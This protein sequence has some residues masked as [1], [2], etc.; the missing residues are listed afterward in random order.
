MGEG[1]EPE[2]VSD[3]RA[4]ALA[5]AI[6]GEVEAADEWLERAIDAA[7]ADPVT[8]DVVIVLREH[9]GRATEHEIAIGELVRGTPFPP[10][11]GADSVQ[12]TTR[13]IA[14]F[15]RYPRDGLVP[16]AARPLPDPRWPWALEQALP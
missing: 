4:R 1:I 16:D 2:S 15:R 7:P 12:R 3:P 11:T 6:L 8:W 5:H 14:S 10:R 13:D 9:W